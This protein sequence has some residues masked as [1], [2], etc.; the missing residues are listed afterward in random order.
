[1]YLDLCL[2]PFYC[3]FCQEGSLKKDPTVWLDGA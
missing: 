2:D 3:Q 1:M